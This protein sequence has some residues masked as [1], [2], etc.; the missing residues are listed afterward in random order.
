MPPWLWVMLAWILVCLVS[1]AIL[2]IAIEK[3]WYGLV[4]REVEQ[5]DAQG[6]FCPECKRPV[7]SA[8]VLHW[9][10]ASVKYY[11][12]EWCGM[13]VCAACEGEHMEG[14]KQ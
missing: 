14:C 5:D 8:A 2:C 13:T 4:E 10:E 6:Q 9:P 1:A 3:G 7:G 12:C 11:V